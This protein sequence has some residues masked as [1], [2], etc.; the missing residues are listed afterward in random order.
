MRLPVFGAHGDRLLRQGRWA[1][2][3]RAE[4]AEPDPRFTLANERTFLAWVRTSLALMAAGIGLEAFVPPL[5][6]PGLRQLVASLV[7]LLGV[8]LSASA[9]GRWFRTEAALRR[10]DPVPA[11]RLAPV[12]SYGVAVIAIAALVAVLLGRR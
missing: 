8:A 2:R 3:L 6:L 4:G 12:L 9:F 10:G 5:A 7:V 1:E 11:P